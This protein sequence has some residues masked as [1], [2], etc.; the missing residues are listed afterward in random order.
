MPNDVPQIAA[1]AVEPQQTN[2][3]F[4]RLAN[5]RNVSDNTFIYYCRGTIHQEGRLDT[6][7]TDSSV[8]EYT[9]SRLRQELVAKYGEE[10]G[11]SLT[12]MTADFMTGKK[13]LKVSDLRTIFGEAER[14]QLEKMQQTIDQEGFPE[15]VPQARKDA[16]FAS[17]NHVAETGGIITRDVM[18]DWILEQYGERGELLKNIFMKS[19]YAAN[20]KVN[21]SLKVLPMIETI[22]GLLEGKSADIVNA[23]KAIYA[24]PGTVGP[25]GVKS[26]LQ[27]TFDVFAT[28]F[29]MF[30]AKDLK[31]PQGVLNVLMKAE[32]LNRVPEADFS[33]LVAA[34][35]T[36]RL[37]DLLSLVDCGMPTSP[38]QFLAQTENTKKIVDDM[39]PQ[40]QAFIMDI[41]MNSKTVDAKGLVAFLSK[42]FGEAVAQHVKD[43]VGLVDDEKCTFERVVSA[44]DSAALRGLKDELLATFTGK[45]PGLDLGGLIDQKIAEIAKESPI[46]AAGVDQ[47]RADVLKASVEAYADKFIEDH[48]DFKDRLEAGVKEDAAAFIAQAKSDEA[49][50]AA[51]Q[52]KFS[53]RL[54][55]LVAED[56][57]SRLVG[58][59]SLSEDVK[60]SLL[61]AVDRAAAEG[62][63]FSGDVFSAWLKQAFEPHGGL[64]QA[65]FLTSAFA[66]PLSR[67]QIPAV[68][69]SMTDIHA[70]LRNEPEPV[71]KALEE[72]YSDGSLK[73]NDERRS[74]VMNQLFG[75]TLADLAVKLTGKDKLDMIDVVQ[76]FGMAQAMKEVASETSPAAVAVAVAM[77]DKRVT[78]APNGTTDPASVVSLR[79]AAQAIH[80]LTQ[81]LPPTELKALEDFCRSG[82]I[83]GKSFAAS[84]EKF[85]GDVLAPERKAELER[86]DK[87]TI[88]QV[89]PF[90]A[91][92]NAKMQEKAAQTIKDQF[93]AQFG[94][95]SQEVNQKLDEG[96]RPLIEG[97]KVTTS[98]TQVLVAQY[99]AL[100]QHIDEVRDSL[101]FLL[102]QDGEALSASL[103]K[104][105][106][107]GA[108]QMRAHIGSVTGEQIRTFEAQARAKFA[109][110]EPLRTAAARHADAPDDVKRYIDE[111][112]ARLMGKADLA[113]ADIDAFVA[114]V[115][116]RL[117]PQ[118]PGRGNDNLEA[119][120][121]EVNPDEV[122]RAA[123]QPGNVGEDHNNVPPQEVRAGNDA[124]NQNEVENEVRAE[125]PGGEN[126]NAEHA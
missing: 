107:D 49:S 92:G 77:Q 86:T 119:P 20:F 67:E 46:R 61:A 55:K 36:A 22:N 122:A 98:P 11:D 27:K 1:Q 66:N 45:A 116:N 99:E 8:N 78:L 17:F 117:Q 42:H 124:G 9:F 126:R 4:E 38:D 16:L 109:E 57:R 32:A 33:H 74:G 91:D 15:H 87:C 68:V 7:F 63:V 88:E 65:M 71:L 37:K 40:I 95:V 70:I 89:L 108:A 34:A 35:A 43:A 93:R 14:L 47:V 50:F 114:E 28:T 48:A 18:A 120:G 24:A 21:D 60:N 80:Q 102:P 81:Q 12:P 10:I 85:F 19:E 62:V 101:K 54:A 29:A 6:L 125:E 41:C 30:E 82:D 26:V 23:M 13:Q 56:I 69:K 112:V 111:E 76:A 105:I 97:K 5:N 64:V 59:Q 52:T 90:I 106:D 110:Q 44:A 84:L 83:S 25:A 121:E 75:S 31:T 118:E 51:L 2:F 104:F 53:V 94:E 96:L 115:Q 100:R 103:V 3:G 113:K 72:F 58:E 73:V 39:P 79:E 123:E